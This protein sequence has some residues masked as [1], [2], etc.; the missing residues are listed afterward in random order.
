VVLDAAGADKP[1]VLL[2]DARGLVVVP[3]SGRL[4]AALGVDD[5]VIVDT[6]DVL[7]ICPRDR[8]QDVKRLVDELKERG[9]DT[10][11]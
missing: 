8:S 10:R 11:L 1:E 2:K 6:P 9:S 3:Q 5:L 4:V 7:M